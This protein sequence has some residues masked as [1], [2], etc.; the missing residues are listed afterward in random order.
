MYSNN[1][2]LQ[3]PE[4]AVASYFKEETS[5][6]WSLQ[7]PPDD[8]VAKESHRYPIGFVTTGFVRGR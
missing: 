5:G 7:A 4:S 6:K 3:L 8:P 2:G 1:G